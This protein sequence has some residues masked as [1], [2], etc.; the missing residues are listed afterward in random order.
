M[1]VK[2]FSFT[3]GGANALTRF[4]AFHVFFIFEKPQGNL[5]PTSF[6]QNR[7]ENKKLKKTGLKKSPSQLIS[8]KSNSK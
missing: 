1:S 4:H 8:T 2:A 6:P 7:N 3:H 5:A